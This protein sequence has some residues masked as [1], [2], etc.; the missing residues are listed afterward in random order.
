MPHHVG[1]CSG[2]LRIRLKRDGNHRSSRARASAI[3]K[4]SAVVTLR[5]Y[6]ESGISSTG[7]PA[8]SHTSAS[9]P[10]A[11][12]FAG[13]PSCAY[14]SCN[15]CRGKPCGVCARQIRSRSTVRVMRGVG[16]GGP[17]PISLSVSDVG[18]AAT[19]PTPARARA[20][21]ASIVPR[22]T[23]GRAAS[24][25]RMIVASS[26]NA[27][28]PARTESTRCATTV[29]LTDPP[30]PDDLEVA[31]GSTGPGGQEH[32]AEALA[33]RFGETALDA[34][35][36]TDFAAKA[37]LAEEQCIGRDRAIMDGGD[38]GGKDGKVG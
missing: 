30:Q 16:R 18:T 5:L 37:R 17:W 20:M 1:D 3:R 19:A 4:S 34:G 22:L 38:E 14:A 27:S 33:R 21:T 10:G 23:N 7:N 2:N 29:E 8:R 35:D 6:G 36:W 12:P 9:S 31:R 25:T 11:P 26:D 32:A 13:A 28:S 24:C 15:I